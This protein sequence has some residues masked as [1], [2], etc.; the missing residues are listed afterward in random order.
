MGPMCLITLSE[1]TTHPIRYR[2]FPQ[3]WGWDPRIR[4]PNPCD[5]ERGTGPSSSH[6]AAGG[7]P[8][9]LAGS[10]SRG[11]EQVARV[12]SL[13]E[14]ARRKGIGNSGSTSLIDGALSLLV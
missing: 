4:C 2:S 8:L 12:E 10:R 3:G 9:A 7:S 13:G 5:Q 11:I 1:A 6:L 14:P